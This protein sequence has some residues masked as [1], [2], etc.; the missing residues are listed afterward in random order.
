MEK[1]KAVRILHRRCAKKGRLSPVDSPS[2]N[3]S[4]VIVQLDDVVLATSCVGS[5][6][7]HVAD[8]Q[9]LRNRHTARGERGTRS[10]A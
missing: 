2:D 9:Q 5:R 8:V 6:N 10:D 3:A 7:G 4:K 1:T